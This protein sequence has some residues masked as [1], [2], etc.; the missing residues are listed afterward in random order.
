MTRFAGVLDHQVRSLRDALRQHQE[1]RCREIVA[2]AER[3]AK[4]AI[5]DSRGKLRERQLQAVREERRQREHDLQ[6]TRSRVETRRRRRAFARHERIL[7]SAWPQLID[8]LEERWSIAEQRRAWCNMIVSEAAATLTGP[9]W[10]IEHPP[11][12]TR[13]DRDAVVQR[14]QQLQIAAPKFVACENISSGLRIRTGSACVDGTTDGLLSAR[15]DVE[16]LLLA[17]WERHHKEH[18]G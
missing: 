7:Q 6:T 9:D 5:R 12:W 16:A 1:R 8:A 13:E 17:A 4:Q 10:V 15:R 2:A 14:L 3:E 11:G 18:H